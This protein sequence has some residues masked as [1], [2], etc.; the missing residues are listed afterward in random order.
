MSTQIRPIYG[1]VDRT[2]ER[3]ADRPVSRPLSSDLWILGTLALARLLLHLYGNG[4]YGF[5]RDELDILD[6]ARHLAWGYVAY[7]PLTPLLARGGLEVF[8]PSLLGLRM[9]PASAQAIAMVLVGLMARDMGGGRW[10]MVVATLAMA[11]APVAMM[12]GLL[13]QYMAFDY[14]WWIVVAWAVVRVIRS[15]DPRWWPAVG[16]AIG[17]GLMTKY[18]MVFF[19]LGVAAGVLLTPLRRHLRSPWLWAGAGLALLI[20]L[21]N[22]LWQVQHDFVTLD[23]LQ[24]IRARDIAWGRTDGFLVEQLYVSVSPVT[25]PLWVAGLFAIWFTPRLRPFAA[26]G[27]MFVLPLVLFLAQQGRAYY[28]APAYPMLMAA[29]TVW[30]EGRLRGWRPRMQRIVQGAVLG[31]MLIGVALATVVTLPIAPIHSQLWDVA[32]D[33]NGELREMIGWPELVAAVAQVYQELPPEEQA[34]TGIFTGNYGETG[35]L[36][37]YGPTYG[38]PEPISGANSSW[39][40]GYGDPPP[41]T[42]IVVGIPQEEARAVFTECHVAGRNPN[43]YNVLNEETRWHMNILLCRGLKMTWQEL[44]PQVQQYQ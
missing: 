28:I 18:T 9:L 40:R 29:G 42:L 19:A 44:W 35:A 26:L 3:S 30:L 2:S 36:A 6:N 15:G 5:H 27:W 32:N 4:H 14:F 16:A 1:T 23:F 7:P 38:L 21:P 10:A 37:L 39:Y 25:I 33:L 12:A 31:L 34:V 20:C 43:P 22:L 8:G 13:L 41:Q 17:L 24:S 11:A